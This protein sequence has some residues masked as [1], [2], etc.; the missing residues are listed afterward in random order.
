MQQ[1]IPDLAYFEY[2]LVSKL[3]IEENNFTEGE[4]PSEALNMMTSHTPAMSKKQWAGF[5]FLLANNGSVSNPT[6]AR[7]EY[8]DAGSNPK[9]I[10]VYIQS[11]HTPC[12]GDTERQSLGGNKAR[13]FQN[14]V[15][16][17]ETR[18]GSN[19]ADDI[20]RSLG[21]NSF[22][23]VDYMGYAGSL[24]VLW[25]QR[26]INLNNQ[27]SIFQEIHAILEIN[28]AGLLSVVA[29]PLLAGLYSA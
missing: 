12:K 26:E 11:E 15:F 10:D 29:I 5:G 28:R 23:K 4:I 25:D 2:N 16:V 9:S 24:W 6:R 13:S 21:F 3:L 14:V 1:K 7:V 22:Y 17:S 8:Q 20:L 18:V 19:R 27:G